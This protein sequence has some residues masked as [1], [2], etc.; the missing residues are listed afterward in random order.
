MLRTILRL[1]EYLGVN[2]DRSVK[3]HLSFRSLTRAVNNY[4]QPPHTTPYVHVCQIGD[5]VLRTHAEPVKPETI[6]SPEFQRVSLNS[7]GAQYQQFFLLNF[8]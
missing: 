5:P 7:V 2:A 8:N 6:P 4:F 1:S 3:R